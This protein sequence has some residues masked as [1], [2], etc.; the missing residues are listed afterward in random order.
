M[1]RVQLQVWRTPEHRM[2]GNDKTYNER[3]AGINSCLSRYRG[4]RIALLCK[5]SNA[6]AHAFGIIV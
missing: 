2:I 3:S 6:S 5:I 1:C 4:S